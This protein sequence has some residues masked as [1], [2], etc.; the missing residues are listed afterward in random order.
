MILDALQGAYDYTY[1]MTY[2]KLECVKVAKRNGLKGPIANAV[3]VEQ[4]FATTLCDLI[5]AIELLQIELEPA[6]AN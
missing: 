3:F 1:E 6:P 2:D 4:D 5:S